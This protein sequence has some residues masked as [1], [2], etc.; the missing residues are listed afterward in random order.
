MEM[1]RQLAGVAPPQAISLGDKQHPL[2]LLPLLFSFMYQE[3]LLSPSMWPPR[4]IWLRITFKKLA[5]LRNLTPG[6]LPK[7][8][9]KESKFYEINVVSYNPLFICNPPPE[10]LEPKEFSEVFQIVIISKQ[11][12]KTFPG[13][14][15]SLIFWTVYIFNDVFDTYILFNFCLFSAV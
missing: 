14:L 1:W 11:L 13:I 10:Q 4:V 2:N 7:K 8:A 9:V 5:D 15:S 12:F 6:L 3:G